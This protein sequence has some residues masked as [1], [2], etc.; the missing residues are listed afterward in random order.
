MGNRNEV[1]IRHQIITFTITPV[2]GELVSTK[3]NF[4]STSKR[5]CSPH[6]MLV[7][8]RQPLIGHRSTAIGT[9]DP[10]RQQEISK[11]AG[12]Q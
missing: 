9:H 6:G 10:L 1:L 5:V 4:Y 7:C 3:I 2:Q 11:Q 12:Y 8:R